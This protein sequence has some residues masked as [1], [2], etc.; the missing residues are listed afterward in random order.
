MAEPVLFAEAAKH[1]RLASDTSEQAL[2]ESY[3]VAAREWVENYTGHVLVQREFTETF[4]RFPA[5]LELMKRPIVTVDEI[6][7]VDTDGA[8]QT[9]V[10][11]VESTGRYPY[12]VYPAHNAWWPSIRTNTLVT[13]TFTAGYAPGE[14]PQALLQAI[15]LLVG[16][17]FQT[18]ATV[19]VG[20]IVTEV[21]FAVSALCDQ[22][23][24][25]GL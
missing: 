23:R 14:E 8:P 22:Y 25:P 11:F 12:S 7:Y 6:A 13:V 16:H 1:L 20:N 2:I 5:Y 21:P 10:S 18:R 9:V 19:N 24:V 3:I 17:W 15:L 4:T